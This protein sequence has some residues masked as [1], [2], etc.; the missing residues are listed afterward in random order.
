M[1]SEILPIFTQSRHTFYCHHLAIAIISNSVQIRRMMCA[2]WMFVLLCPPPQGEGIMQWWPLSVRLSVLCF[3]LSREWKGIASWKLAGGKP[4]TR[5]TLDPIYGSKGQRSRSPGWLM[6]RRK[7]S[8]IFG[9]GRPTNFKLHTRMEYKDMHHWHAQWPQRSK[10]KVI[11]WHYQ[12]DT[13][14]H[15]S[16]KK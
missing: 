6:L 12:L 13:F 2:L 15:N 7:I 11:T 8:H 10:V 4:K 14:A 3:I 1:P 16:T 9:T 5:V